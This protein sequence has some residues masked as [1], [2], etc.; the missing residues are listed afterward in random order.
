MLNTITFSNVISASL[1]HPDCDGP[2]VA[3]MF[4]GFVPDIIH[5]SVVA[6]SWWN[7][8]IW[9]FFVNPAVDHVSDFTIF[10]QFG[11]EISASSVIMPMPVNV[12]LIAPS[13]GHI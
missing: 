7:V 3:I 4:S 12:S 9:S 10:K 5:T 1:V 6:G 13:C 2:V 8:K 11:V